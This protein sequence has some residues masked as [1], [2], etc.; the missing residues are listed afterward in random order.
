MIYTGHI[1]DWNKDIKDYYLEIYW[2]AASNVKMGF[3]PK[4]VWM[5]DFWSLVIFFFESL[6]YCLCA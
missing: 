4:N 5:A 6:C 3:L 2:I 1:L